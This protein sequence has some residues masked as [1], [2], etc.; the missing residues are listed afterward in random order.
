MAASWNWIVV[1]AALETNRSAQTA[2]FAAVA[3]ATAPVYHIT[4]VYFFFL[5]EIR[6]TN[7]YNLFSSKFFLLT[8]AKL[9]RMGN[10][11]IELFHNNVC[12]L[13]EYV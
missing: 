4:R 3:A 11:F 1:D 2:R 5:H 9:F 8:S 13:N 12:S 7:D 6:Q 10:K